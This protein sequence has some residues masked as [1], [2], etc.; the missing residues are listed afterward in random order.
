MFSFFLWDGKPNISTIN[1]LLVKKLTHIRLSGYNN[2]QINREI[3]ESDYNDLKALIR[4]LGENILKANVKKTGER[5]DFMEIRA[6]FVKMTDVFINHSN[7][8][9]ITT[10]AAQLL[11]YYTIVCNKNFHS[12]QDFPSFDRFL[13][14]N[15]RTL[16]DASINAFIVEYKLIKIYN[17]LST[18]VDAIS[19]TIAPIENSE[20]KSAFLKEHLQLLHETVSNFKCNAPDNVFSHYLNFVSNYATAKALELD[21]RMLEMKLAKSTPEDEQELSVKQQIYLDNAKES[22]DEIEKLPLFFEERNSP[23]VKGM[24]FSFGQDV[25]SKLP[26]RNIGEIIEHVSALL[27]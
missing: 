9:T 10:Y 25:F 1:P 15:K 27:N 3:L 6:K 14:N 4:E 24:E 26:V 11:Q 12:E 18:L 23:H 2:A 17:D 21:Y 22:L 7:V 13:F 20:Q 5:N 16:G 8:Y 19:G